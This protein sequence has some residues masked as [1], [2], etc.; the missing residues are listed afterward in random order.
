[1]LTLFKPLIRSKLEYCSEI[2][3]PHKIKEINKIE[4]IQRTFTSRIAGMQD[5]NYWQRLSK[6]KIMSL[7]RRREK[8][9]ILHIWKICN[10]VYP[11]SIGIDFKINPRTT[12]TQAI[13]KPLPKIRGKILTLYDESFIIREIF[14]Y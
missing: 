6:L 14:S 2:F 13:I 12:S 10:G 7:Q 4:Q 3:N 9:I 11:N 1:M 5:S 8:N